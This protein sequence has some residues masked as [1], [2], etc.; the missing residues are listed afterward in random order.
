MKSLPDLLPK[1]PEELADRVRALQLLGAVCQAGRMKHKHRRELET[2]LGGQVSQQLAAHWK[3]H[4]KEIRRD[5]AEEL[6]SDPE[7]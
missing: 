7:E 4:L 5:L 6:K 3:K 1:V 2:L